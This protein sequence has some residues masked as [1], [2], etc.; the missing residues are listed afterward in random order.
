M[1]ETTSS[2]DH[3]VA[4]IEDW[5][6]LAVSKLRKIITGSVRGI[7]ESILNSEPVYNSGGPCCNI[8][9]YK[10]HVNLEFWR[11]I[12]LSNQFPV[13]S[14]TGRKKRHIRISSTE[15]IQEKLFSDIVQTAVK[16]NQILGDPRIE[17]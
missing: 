15:D 14:G 10:N 13:L 17:D 5:Q 6:S 7:K 4:S 8:K 16:L 9:T 11:G 3:Y 1:S 12:E 2:V